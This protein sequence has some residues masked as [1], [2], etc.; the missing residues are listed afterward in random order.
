[1]CVCVCVSSI[2]LSKTVCCLIIDSAVPESRGDERHVAMTTSALKGSNQQPQNSI[3]H[4]LFFV[5]VKKK[6]EQI[7]SLFTHHHKVEYDFNNL[8]CAELKFLKS[9]LG[10]NI[11]PLEHFLHLLATKG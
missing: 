3:S 11:L 8:T 4:F 10:V 1:M 9:Q 6:S 7:L 2:T 5:F